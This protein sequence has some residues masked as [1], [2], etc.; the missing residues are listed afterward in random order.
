M[1]Y[2]SWTMNSKLLIQITPSLD[3]KQERSFDDDSAWMFWDKYGI[4]SP[5][6]E[7]IAVSEECDINAS[8]YCSPLNLQ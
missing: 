8:Q 5:S 3:K 1:N 6:V 7:V 4:K 2:A